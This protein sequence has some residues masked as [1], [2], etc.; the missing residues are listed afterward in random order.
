MGA[1]FLA[2]KLEEAP[3][4]IRD[5]IN[6]YDY[7]IQRALHHSKHRPGPRALEKRGGSA[8]KNSASHPSASHP[9]L[10]A[11]PGLGSPQRAAS[12][13]QPSE[14]VPP[15]CYSPPAYFAQSFYDTKDA[16]V[17]AEMQI[18][19]RLGFNVQVNLPYATAVNYL[20][21]LGLADS[22]QW[23]E[24]PQRAWGYLNDA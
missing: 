22:E 13:S 2:A 11:R 3:L 17:I 14:P 16:L 21:V 23:P 15:F 18:L 4:R 12:P 8:Y 24:A 19:K 1:L 5:L 20:Q 6:V 10:P 9:S 7:L